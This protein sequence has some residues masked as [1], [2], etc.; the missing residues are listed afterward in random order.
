ML[1]CR[2]PGSS[3]LVLH[4]PHIDVK[5]FITCRRHETLSLHNILQSF[6]TSDC[7]WLVP[8]GPGA[9][10]QT[11]VSVSDAL[12]R[13]ELLEDFLFWYFDSFV[14]PLL[15]VLF[16]HFINNWRL[17]YCIIQTTFYITE[18]SAFKN[19]VLYFRHDDWDTLCAPLIERLTSV[20]FE[21]L[22]DVSCP[23]FQLFSPPLKSS[24]PKLQ[25]SCANAV[26]GFR[27][28]D[29]CQKKRVCGQLSIC[30]GRKLLPE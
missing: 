27:S 17:N 23:L 6:S 7:D 28:S 25:R 15:R 4:W 29:C 20:T 30:A 10:K 12:K 19:Q 3:I 22:P 16:D 5:D 9:L 14:L 1:R 26:S 21:Q 18:S 2:S 11:R 13:R 24:S 8:P